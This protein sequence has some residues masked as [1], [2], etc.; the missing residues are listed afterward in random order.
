MYGMKRICLFLMVTLTVVGRAA[1]SKR[2]IAVVRD[3]VIKAVGERTIAAIRKREGGDKFLKA[4]LSD[5]DWLEQFAGSGRPGGTASRFGTYADA[6]KALDL[7]VWND[8][9]DFIKTK[10][11]R[12]IATALALNHG[13]DWDER[14]LVLHMECYREW[15]K[16]GTLHDTAW[17]LDTWGWRE[18]VTMGQ[19]EH[20]TVEDL[21]WIHDYATIPAAQY[22]GVCWTC[23][24]RLNNCFGATVHGPQYYEPWQH[25]WNTQELRFR[26]G[27]VCGALSKFG[28]HCAASHGVRSFTAGQP[29][30]CAFM[31]WDFDKNRWGQAYSVTSHTG[32]HF[33]LGGDGWPALEEQNRY[34]S[35]SRRMDAEYLRW[36]G[37]FESAMKLVPGNWNAAYDWLESIKDHPS[38]EEWEKLAE[39][40]RTTF[41][42]DPCQG[43]QLYCKYL[44]G[45]SQNKSARIEAA[46]KGLL[47]FK[48]NE[49]P[50]YEPMYFDERVLTPLFKVIG[51]DEATIWELLPAILDGQGKS[52][53]YYTAAINWAANRLMKGP[54][55]SK[56][57][58]KTVGES[59]LKWKR[60][61]D[62]RGM[63]LTASESEDIGMF[64]QV[65]VLM[66]K[67]APKLA[68]KLE[69]KAYPENDYGFPLLSKEGL[70]KISKTSEWDTPVNYR[71]VIDAPNFAGGNGFHTGK[72][73]APWAEV[74]LPGDCEVAGLTI[75]NSGGGQNG[76]RQVPLEVSLSTDGSA[77]KTVWS[78]EAVQDTWNVKLPSP[79]TA[80]YIRVGRREG[81]KE[82]VFHLH[83][84]LVYGKKLY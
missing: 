14:K 5:R 60:D 56:R 45:F 84:I 31:L 25:R 68:P 30:H 54:E 10:L 83:K 51:E 7:L 1:E 59:A 76:G 78:S 65:Y 61:L 80:K 11:G 62:Y 16:D 9:D 36:K 12:N 79:V 66:D 70:L 44:E 38:A 34:Y 67:L 19:N 72:D 63:I 64:R 18:V 47:A 73:K 48:E 20:L 53:N 49:A 21:R 69:G 24:Y 52:K 42:T 81:A 35:N 37:E 39:A 40:L 15:A 13:W 29:G 27:G 32:A 17:D 28:S 50:T 23:S 77:F 43:W 75:V 41:K 2:D 33:T 71:N 46:R 57:F 6:L 55:S 74:V 4:F 26:V 58:L 82:E 8:E 3:Y 22:A